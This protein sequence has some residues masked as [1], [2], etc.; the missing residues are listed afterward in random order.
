MSSGDVSP[1]PPAGKVSGDT[2]TPQHKWGAQM[3]DVNPNWP[4]LWSQSPF[5]MLLLASR[6]VGKL[7]Q[8]SSK[9]SECWDIAVSQAG[10]K[11]SECWA[12]AVSQVRSKLSGCWA[13]AVPQSRGEGGALMLEGS[14]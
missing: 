12:V 2:P 5:L 14:R 10:S 8:A 13:V 4:L 9:L 6:C 11:L 3:K 7:C 1:S